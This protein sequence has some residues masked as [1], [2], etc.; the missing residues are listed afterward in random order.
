MFPKN[1]SPS[2]LVP[3]DEELKEMIENEKFLLELNEIMLELNDKGREQVITH[4]IAIAQF[5]RYRK[6]R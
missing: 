2:D 4:M 6:D 5:E 3:S 1:I